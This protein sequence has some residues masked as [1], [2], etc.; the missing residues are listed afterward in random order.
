MAVAITVARATVAKPTVTEMRAPYTTRLQ[1]SRDRLSV[2]IQN[3]AL[4]GLVR[5]AGI[6][7]SYGYGAM[8]LA[9]TAITRRAKTITPPMAP[10]GLRRPKRSTV[11]ARAGRR[12]ARGSGSGTDRVWTE[13]A[14]GA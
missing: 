7:W 14:I 8:R 9:K 10:S 4:G 3:W 2:P 11:R 12:H 1:T 13:F 6:D 5:A